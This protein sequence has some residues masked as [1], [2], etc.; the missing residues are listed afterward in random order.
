MPAGTKGGLMCLWRPSS[1]GLSPEYQE[2]V[3]EEI[4]NLKH[5]GGWSFFEAYN[6]PIQLRRW[7]VRRLVEEFEKQNEEMEK[8]TKE[9]NATSQRFGP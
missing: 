4:F 1:F 3:Y 9:T 7:F 8:A 2:G 6:L 5:H